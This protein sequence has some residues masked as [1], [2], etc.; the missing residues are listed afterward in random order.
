MLKKRAKEEIKGGKRTKEKRKK[1]SVKIVN[2]NQ[3]AKK[4]QIFKNFNGVKFIKKYQNLVI[5][6]SRKKS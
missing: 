4:G 2:S 1:A 6:K 5:S 3:K